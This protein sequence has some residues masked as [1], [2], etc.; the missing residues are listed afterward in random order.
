[1]EFGEEEGEVTRTKMENLKYTRLENVL[2]SDME[3]KRKRFFYC[4]SQ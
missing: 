1:V 4:L 3:H 2:I